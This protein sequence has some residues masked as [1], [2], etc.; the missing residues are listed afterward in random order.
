MK[1]STGRNDNLHINFI[2]VGYN[3]GVFRRWRLRY[4]SHLRVGS[5]HSFSGSEIK[6]KLNTTV[7]AASKI[8][9]ILGWRCLPARHRRNGP[10]KPIPSGEPGSKHR[11]FALAWLT[12]PGS[13]RHL[14]NAGFFSLHLVFHTNTQEIPAKTRLGGKCCDIWVLFPWSCCALPHLGG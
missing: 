6:K 2:S 11:L 14:F 10:I 1:N 7:G 4:C 8:F 5:L 3:N 12:R 9:H 13:K